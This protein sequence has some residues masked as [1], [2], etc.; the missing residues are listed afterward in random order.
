[1]QAVLA[2]EEEAGADARIDRKITATT[3]NPTEIRRCPARM[4][5]DDPARL[6]DAADLD[7]SPRVGVAQQEVVSIS[8][9]GGTGSTPRCR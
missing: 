3:K 7:P 4:A 5:I 8:A 2:A 6:E 1:V 9:A